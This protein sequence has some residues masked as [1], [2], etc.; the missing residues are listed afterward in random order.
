MD[1]D[2]QKEQLKRLPDRFLRTA[3]AYLVDG[4]SVRDIAAEQGIC[5]RAV[6]RR[7]DLITRCTGQPI[8]RRS[9]RGR[10]RKA[11]A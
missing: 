3:Q 11:V 6:Y 8:H 2:A 4:L 10:P 9:R 1:R 5:L 7:L